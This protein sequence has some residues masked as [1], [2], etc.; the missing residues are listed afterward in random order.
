MATPD[1]PSSA[2]DILD[3]HIP[4]RQLPT[5]LEV[6]GISSAFN[7]QVDAVVV[8][9]ITE[10]ESENHAETDLHPEIE[11]DASIVEPPSKIARSD[12]RERIAER[13]NRLSDRL[14]RMVDPRLSALRDIAE[15]TEAEKLE[16]EVRN[17]LQKIRLR[18]IVIWIAPPPIPFKF[19]PL[20]LFYI[21]Y[22]YS[23]I[24]GL[25]RKQLLFSMNK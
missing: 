17:H 11:L 23:K 1:T 8:I 24:I 13:A 10:P 21:L 6:S 4:S 15:L 19:V 7:E 5:S 14:T 12:V 20:I 16:L 2:K 3:R 25:K 9:E 18:G 22:H